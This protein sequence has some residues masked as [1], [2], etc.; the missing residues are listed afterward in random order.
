MMN[1]TSEQGNFGIFSA[2]TDTRYERT[3][4]KNTSAWKLLLRLCDDG[5]FGDAS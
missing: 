2:G 1:G 4:G 5:F 3:G